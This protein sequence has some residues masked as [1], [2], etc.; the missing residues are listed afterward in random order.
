MSKFKVLKVYRDLEKNKLHKIGD[1]TELTDARAKEVMDKLGKDFISK[2]ETD[3]E[4]AK[5][6]KK[7]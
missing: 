7:K 2:I 3:K 4:V 5:P 1:I 6:K